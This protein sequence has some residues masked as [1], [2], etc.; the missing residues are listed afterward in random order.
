MKATVIIP[1]TGEDCLGDAISSVIYSQ[2][3]DTNCYVV[4]DGEEHFRKAKKI[5]YQFNNHPMLKF[6]VLPVNVGADGYYGHRI[7]AAFSHLINTEYLLFLDQDNWFSSGHVKSCIDT[8][9]EFNLDW[10]YSLRKI[11]DKD[12]NYVCADNCESLGTWESCGGYKHIDTN[13]YCIRTNVAARM[14]SV[15]HGGWGQDRVYREVLSQHYP[16]CIGT[17][18]HTVSYR[19][20][21]NDGSVTKEF[22]GQGNKFMNEKYNGE[23]PW[24]KKV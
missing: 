10:T 23:F 11:F 8:I 12:G 17:G 3:I 20:A 22:F 7:Y 18:Q 13:C 15:W 19:L 6:S 2:T 14:A 16:K 21:G 9:E 5:L 24:V 1:T 4:I